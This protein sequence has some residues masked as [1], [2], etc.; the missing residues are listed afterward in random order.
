MTFERGDELVKINKKE[1][2]DRYR[3]FNSSYAK[4]EDFFNY[5]TQYFKFNL[6]AEL[7]WFI[8]REEIVEENGV[9]V[10]NSGL[11]YYKNIDPSYNDDLEECVIRKVFRES[12]EEYDIYDAT[13]DF[14]KINK[15]FSFQ[16]RMNHEKENNL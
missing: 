11:Y 1:T 3:F 5:N 16:P 9:D 10:I 4:P 14:E 7:T 15:L 6:F 2:K 12:K 13:Y 8:G